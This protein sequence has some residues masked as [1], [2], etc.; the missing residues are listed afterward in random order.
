M[1]KHT[2]KP[3]TNNKTTKQLIKQTSKFNKTK[4]N[5]LQQT[6]LILAEQPQQQS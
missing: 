2:K 3:K 4:I 5:P 1:N 6:T